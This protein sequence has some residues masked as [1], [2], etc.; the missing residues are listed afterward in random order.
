MGVMDRIGEHWK[1]LAPRV[2]EVPEWGD[3]TDKPLLIYG[4]P[5]NVASA[6]KIFSAGKNSSFEMFVEAL[7]QLACN[8]TGEKLFTIADRP[9]LRRTAAKEI[10]ERVGLELI[11]ARDSDEIAPTHEARVKN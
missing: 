6:D 1:S 4:M 2:I 7:I 8:E 9:V 11:K 5:M 10:I 3:A